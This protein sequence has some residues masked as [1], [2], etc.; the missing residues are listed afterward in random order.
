MTDD[1]ATDDQ[2]LRGLRLATIR[3]TRC[4]HGAACQFAMRT[5]R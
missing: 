3:G 2:A 1:L 5:V 4:D